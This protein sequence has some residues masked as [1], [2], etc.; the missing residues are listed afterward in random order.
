MKIPWTRTIR[1]AIGYYRTALDSGRNHEM[2][3]APLMAPC[4]IRGMRGCLSSSR[5]ASNVWP[6]TD[7]NRGF[8]PGVV[9]TGS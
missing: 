9:P 3:K 6:E 7:S 4:A 5:V 1:V 2:H 8:V